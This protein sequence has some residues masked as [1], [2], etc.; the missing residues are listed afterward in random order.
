MKTFSANSIAEQFEKDRGVVVRALRDTKADAV[1][2][3]KPRWKIAT[4]AKALERHRNRNG[5]NGGVNVQGRNRLGDIA[6]ELERL[7]HELDDVIALVK[8]LP[9]LDSKQPHS[10]A[11][12]LLLLQI[13]EL[14]REGNELLIKDDRSSLAP[15]VTGPL[16]GG[17][18]RKLLAA[19]YGPQMTLDG[20]RL[21]SDDEIKQFGLA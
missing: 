2:A 7:L 5:G 8:S 17:Y 18:F 15:Y 10:R 21:W 16:V 19:V 20:E 14:Y 11:A 4:A 1:V 13:D 6:Y 3:G 9:D 12:G